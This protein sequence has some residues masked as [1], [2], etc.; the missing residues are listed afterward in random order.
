MT[1]ASRR[2][3]KCR[4]GKRGGGLKAFNAYMR[5]Y[6]QQPHVQ[7]KSRLQRAHWMQTN[8]RYFNLYQR[9]RRRLHG[10]LCKCGKPASARATLM[11]G[12]VVCRWC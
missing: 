11:L 12:E 7:E 10:V 1:P 8:R 3:L 5:S 4:R 9:V 6:R 2:T